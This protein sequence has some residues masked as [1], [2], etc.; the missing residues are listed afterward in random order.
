MTYRGYEIT[1]EKTPYGVVILVNTPDGPFDAPTVKRAKQYVDAMI[2]EA[3]SLRTGIPI[4][5]T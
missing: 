2:E 5:S 4:S 1:K 3:E